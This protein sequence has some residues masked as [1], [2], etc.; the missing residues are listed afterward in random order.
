MKTADSLRFGAASILAATAFGLVASQSAAAHS[1]VSTA[2]C[3][4]IHATVH[5]YDPANTNRTDVYLDGSLIDSV[6]FAVN[7]DKDYSV[8]QDA[9]TH[10]WRVNVDSSDDEW[11]RDTGT[12]TVGPCGVVTTEP[13]TTTEAPTTTGAPTTTTTTTELVTTTD[14]PTTITTELVTTTDA[15]TT[16]TDLVTTT[17]DLVTATT[18]APTTTGAPETTTA[19]APTTT[20]QPPTAPP[21]PCA[22]PIKRFMRS[23]GNTPIEIYDG[24][25]T[26]TQVYFNDNW[27][28][29]A[30][31]WTSTVPVSYVDVGTYLY[32]PNNPYFYNP[33]ATSGSGLVGIP[34]ADGSPAR[35]K[36][37]W[38]CFEDSGQGTTTTTTTTETP[39]TTEVEVTTTTE[40]PVTDVEVT[41]TTETPVTD[42]E[43]TTTTETPVTTDVEVTTTEAPATTAPDVAITTETPATTDEDVTTTTATPADPA[44][45][46]PNPPQ[47][48]GDSGSRPDDPVPASAAGAAPEGTLPQTGT[49]AQNLAILATA[50]VLLGGGVLLTTRTRRQL[51]R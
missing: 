35:L 31:D 38:V 43:V 9:N 4:G 51:S 22:T 25:M 8:P 40:T 1:N 21:A 36:S 17:T 18:A 37:L 24:R 33:P 39:A 2:D 50:L 16:T 23:W 29:I 44:P 5:S 12:G 14:A 46:A 34:N 28:P 20:T 6:T 47:V 26:I 19:E 27:D 13:T 48:G 30:F 3:G 11:D 41:T 42:V 15:P 10:T 7:V 49:A 32:E 45:E